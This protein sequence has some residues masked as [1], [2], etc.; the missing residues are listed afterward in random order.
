[1]RLLKDKKVSSFKDIKYDMVK[2]CLPFKN[3]TVTRMLTISL[4][5]MNAADLFYAAITSKGSYLNFFMK[6]NVPGIATFFI[7]LGKDI[8]YS[9]KERKL[10]WEKINNT[11]EKLKLLGVKTYLVNKNNL[12]ELEHTEECYQSLVKVVEYSMNRAREEYKE[13]GKNMNS[14]SNSINDIDDVFRKE[15]LDALDW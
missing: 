2:E 1:M 7:N 3:R 12:I 14:I 8:S 10:E 5:V 9:F 15:M 13:I 6:I 11:N 4:G